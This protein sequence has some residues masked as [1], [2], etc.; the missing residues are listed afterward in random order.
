MTIFACVLYALG[1]VLMGYFSRG[2]HMSRAEMIS[3]CA[4]WPL[5]VGFMLYMDFFEVN[6]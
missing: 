3:V 4:I 5:V 2:P 1:A 6:R